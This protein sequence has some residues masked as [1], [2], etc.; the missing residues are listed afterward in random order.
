MNGD[1]TGLQP[2]Y[3]TVILG[4][5][6][7]GAAAGV[8]LRR[9]LPGRSVLIVEKQTAFD[10]KVGEAT[11]EMSGMFLTRRLALWEHLER[12][13]LPKEGLRY[14]FH[15]EHVHGHAQASE[16]G[17][18]QRSTVPSFQLR[19]DVLDEHILATA[20]KEGAT[21][22]RPARAVAVELGQFDHQVTL[23][24]GDRRETVRCRWV[25]DASGRATFL[26][27][28]LGLVE[29]NEE[30]PTAAIW[31]RWKNVRHVDDLAARGPLSFSR[32]NVCSR[33]LATNHY[34]GFGYWIWVI[35]LGNSETS[36]GIVFD[37]RLVDLPTQA[38]RQREAAYR[39]FLLA[40]PSLAE[41]LEGAE[42]RLDDFR[43]YSTLAYVCRQYMGEGWGLL[44]DAAAF[45]DPY[46][47]PGL[48]HASFSVDATVAI[49]KAHLEG[50]DVAPRIAEHNRTFARSYHRFFRAVYKDKYFYMGEHDLLS[51]ATLI[52]T[53]QYY[54]F[55]VMPAYKLYG[56]F[57]W[58]PVLG[59]KPAFISY[60]L[61]Q[62]YNRRFKALALLRRAAGEEG[63]RNHGRRVKMLFD[64]RLSPVRMAARGIKIWLLAELDGVRLAAKR[65]FQ[66]RPQMPPAP[67]PK[68]ERAEV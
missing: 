42:L 24:V 65:L 2:Y 33:R 51:A 41:L 62:L 8:L 47:S 46:Y 32:G 63:R 61:M 5:A 7:S 66:R 20:V 25:L 28:R 54:L 21:L 44:G 13:H 56:R 60:H 68:A 17:A 36:V 67:L 52:D 26:G 43:S 6:F 27:R 40:D 18:F 3:D 10:A 50:E 57:H 58:M 49:V 16:A 1:T 64:L 11:T 38:G 22:L 30:H 14:W 29:R 37:R 48:D 23:E 53:A 4:G 45:L 39:A 19:R 34:V 55:V 12:E 15:N 31:G 59:P 9:D 35:P